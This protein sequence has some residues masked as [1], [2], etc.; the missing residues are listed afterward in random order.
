MIRLVY[1][2]EHQV[3]PRKQSSREINIL[4]RRLPLIVTSK[5]W[6]GCCT[7]SS[8]CIKGCRNSSFS[9]RNSLLFHHLV[10]SR[11]VIL[12]HFIKLINT[13]NTSVGKNKSAPF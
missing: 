13:A 7:Y 2:N 12:F 3:E 6:I 11:S 9:D 8:P 1:E 5:R 10:N 4:F